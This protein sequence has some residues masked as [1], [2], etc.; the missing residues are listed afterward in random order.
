[1][2]PENAPL[3]KE[4]IYKPPIFGFQ[5]WIFEGASSIILAFRLARALKGLRDSVV[6]PKGAG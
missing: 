1:M 2:E 5:P 3:E 6:V 4:I